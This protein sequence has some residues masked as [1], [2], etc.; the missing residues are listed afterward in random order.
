M[1]SAFHKRFLAAAFLTLSILPTAFHANA[2]KVR[3][4]GGRKVGAAEPVTITRTQRDSIRRDSILTDM[5]KLRG[6]A[7]DSLMKVIPDSSI[8][9]VDSL[10]LAAREPILDSLAADTV[11]IASGEKAV[12]KAGNLNKETDSIA[13]VKHKFRFTQDTMKAGR[14]TLL[15]FVPGLGQVYNRQV[16]KVPVFYGAIGGFATAGALFGKSYKNHK[17]DYDR[18]V[19]LGLPPE[20][21]A[22]EQ[23]K[24]RQAGSARTIMFSMMAATYLYSVA[25]ATFNYRGVNDRIRKATT[26]AAVFPGMGFVYTKT[27][28]RLPIYYGGFIAM[29]T[30]IDYNNRSFQR[31]SRAYTAMTDGDPTTESEFGDRYSADI[32][33]NVRNAYRRDRDFAIIATA[34]VYLLSVV[35]THVIA[36]LKNWDVSDD[37][38]FR[39]EPIIINNS[40]ER[41]S[42][43]PRGYGMSLKIRF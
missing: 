20:T 9:M 5:A 16:W 30:V 28:W 22:E 15:S 25:D 23:K 29:A 39:V 18:A 11:F 21:V 37:L 38:S 14:L 34:V 19:N 31:Y 12:A 10:I 7:L 13:P 42:H 8:R 4:E 36:T 33:L 2:Q 6:I 24:M 40:M 41:A 26:L 1:T 17:A 32:I 43:V 3:V 27:Y 35:D